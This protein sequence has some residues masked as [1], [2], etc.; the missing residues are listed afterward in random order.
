MIISPRDKDVTG[1]PDRSP[2]GF[3]IIAAYKLATAGLSLA[4]GF[5]LFRLFRGDA[6]A[7]LEFAIRS[8]R[9]DPENA[10]IHVAIG[11][12]ARVDRKQLELIE[13]GT[14]S[15]AILHAIE[16]IAILRGKRWGAM[17][18]IL[19]TTSLI[20]FECYEIW[21]RSSLLRVAALLS[22]VGIVAYLIGNRRS[23]DGERLST[24]RPARAAGFE[25][26]ES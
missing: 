19:A 14:F 11:R 13:A 17:L 12:L 10:L 3:R 4:L 24:S 2:L 16:G 21:R 22:N 15:Y 5:G 1:A 25:G 6:S 9:L 23:L 18:I 20:P 26:S 7:S 8:L